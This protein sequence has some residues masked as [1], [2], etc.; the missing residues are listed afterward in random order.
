M[1]INWWALFRIIPSIVGYTIGGIF[2]IAIPILTIY[3]W[4]FLITKGMTGAPWSFFGCFLG[5]IVS[6]I[7]I[8]FGIIEI[9]DNNRNKI[10]KPFVT[11]DKKS[12]EKKDPL[13]F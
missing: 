8:W 7:I 9:Y 5:T 6:A 2:L 11:R 3:S 13:I 12:I 10:Q 1:K 4:Y